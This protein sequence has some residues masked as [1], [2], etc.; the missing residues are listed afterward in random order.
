M[1]KINAREL[2]AMVGREPLNNE[3]LENVTGGDACRYS[4][5]ARCASKNS[6]L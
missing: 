1:K 5:A 2:K 4:K 6:A 3:E